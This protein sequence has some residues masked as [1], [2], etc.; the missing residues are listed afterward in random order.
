[1]TARRFWRP[2]WFGI[3]DPRVE[4]QREEESTQKGE[5]CEPPRGELDCKPT[6]VRRR[7]VFC[8]TST[9][10]PHLRRTPPKSAVRLMIVGGVVTNGV[11]TVG[12][13]HKFPRGRGE[14]C[15]GGKGK[16]DISAPAVTPAV[17]LCSYLC[18]RLRFWSLTER[19]HARRSSRPLGE[20]R[21]SRAATRNSLLS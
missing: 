15:G 19:T 16:E 3:W 10:V 12:A 8:T 2:G 18:F 5:K 7:V 6:R 4:E 17:S 21:E 13:V 11:G 1:V 9:L 14:D 20:F